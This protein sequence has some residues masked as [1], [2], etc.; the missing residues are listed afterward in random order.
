[1]VTLP[2]GVKRL[3]KMGFCTT[4]NLLIKAHSETIDINMTHWATDLP[5]CMRPFVPL[6]LIWSS[7]LFAAVNPVACKR[8]VSI[9]PP[10]NH[11]KSPSWQSQWHRS[12]LS[13][14]QSTVPYCTSFTTLCWGAEEAVDV[15]GPMHY[16]YIKSTSCSSHHLTTTTV[17]SFENI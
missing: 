11:N 13:S 2:A 10:D 12:Q 7:K 14:L 17:H 3:V 4:N 5:T 15:D 16:A 1:M 6:Q 8:P 9:V